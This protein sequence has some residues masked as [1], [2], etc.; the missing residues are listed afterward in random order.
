VRGRIVAIG[1]AESFTTA[2][3]KGG[4]SAGDLWLAHA[5]RYL[6]GKQPP[7][8]NVAARSVDQIRL[9]M[10]SRQRRTVMLLSIAGI[11]LAW[12]F[13]GA[14]VVLVRRRRDA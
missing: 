5:V 10:T 1:S 3:L 12:L 6:A 14:L 11:P 9:V 8:V 13:I 4:I 7:K 2:I